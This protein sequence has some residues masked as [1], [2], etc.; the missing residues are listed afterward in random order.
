MAK[1][2]KT[3]N[4]KV[5]IET[6]VQL[7]LAPEDGKLIKAIVAQPEEII[8]QICEYTEAG[9]SFTLSKNSGKFGYSVFCGYTDP[10]S[11][12]SGKGFYANGTEPVSALA[13]AVFKIMNMD[14]R[15]LDDYSA[16]G[17]QQAE[18]S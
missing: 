4:P 16:H 2:P 8:A 7:P 9:W 17:V 6:I 11:R 18:F 15:F 12:N 5:K 14:T 1:Q 13:C 3:T 10:G